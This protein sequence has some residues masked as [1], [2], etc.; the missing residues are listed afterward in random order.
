VLEEI[1]NEEKEA[2]RKLN[3]I[4]EEINLEAAPAATA[5]VKPTRRSATRGR[6]A[7]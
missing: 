2:D 7:A 3:E 5:N 1:L 6:S 4:A